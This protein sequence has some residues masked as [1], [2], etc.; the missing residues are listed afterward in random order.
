M[1]AAW[2]AAWAAE[3]MEATS[4]VVWKGGGGDG[5]RVG[6]GQGSGSDHGGV[7]GGK[8][9]R[10]DEYRR[11]WADG[12]K[13]VWMWR[14][15]KQPWERSERVQCSCTYMSVKGRSLSAS[16]SRSLPSSKIV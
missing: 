16:V 7:G 2:E 1:G 8:G 15:C 9:G 14:R 13:G 11:G 3:V 5:G 6:G 4:E 10:S 12:Q